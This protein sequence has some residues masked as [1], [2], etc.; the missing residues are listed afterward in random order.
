MNQIIDCTSN[1][2]TCANHQCVP[3]SSRCNGREECSDGSDE[4]NCGNWKSFPLEFIFSIDL[5]KGTKFH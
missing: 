4:S 1:E 5:W 3:I 2:F